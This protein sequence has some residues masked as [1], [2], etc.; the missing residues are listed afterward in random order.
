MIF[1]LFYCFLIILL[2]LLFLLLFSFLLDQLAE[3]SAPY[4]KQTA[5]SQAHQSVKTV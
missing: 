2:F 3:G 5:R 1:V 4:S